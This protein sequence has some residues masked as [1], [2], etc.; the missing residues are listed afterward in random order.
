M[1]KNKF[2]HIVTVASVASYAGAPNIIAYAAS[3]SA[4]ARFDHCL[5][6]ELKW[7][8]N[9]DGESVHNHVKTLQVNPYYIS[10]GMFQGAKEVADFKFLTPNFVAG[11]VITAI[12]YCYEEIILPWDLGT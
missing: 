2:G 11:E 9:K 12:Q 3:K 4:A 8:K 1:I 10:T 5:R 6:F 7:M